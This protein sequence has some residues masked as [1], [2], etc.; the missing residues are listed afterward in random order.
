VSKDGL[1]VT[2]D[3]LIPSQAR[4]RFDQQGPQRRLMDVKRLTPQV[5]T[6]Q[7]N[8]VEGVQKDLAIVAPI[9]N[10]V[11]HWEPVVVAGNRLAVDD[12]RPVRRLASCGASTG[13]PRID[14]GD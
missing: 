4:S 7:L 10:S 9:S 3:V 1:A 6:I 11:K 8:K 12:A 2:L 14:R 5:V 13:C